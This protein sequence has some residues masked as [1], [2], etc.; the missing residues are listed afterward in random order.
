MNKAVTSIM[1]QFM[2]G[3]LGIM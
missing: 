1:T 2:E 3:T